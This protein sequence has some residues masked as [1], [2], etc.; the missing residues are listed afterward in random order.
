MPLCENAAVGSTVKIRFSPIPGSV[1]SNGVP[2]VSGSTQS[3]CGDESEASGHECADLRFAAISEV[4][5]AESN[6]ENDCRRPES[7]T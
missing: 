5:S 6:R 2:D 4:D 1:H 3:K 7:D